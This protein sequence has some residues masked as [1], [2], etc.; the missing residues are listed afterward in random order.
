VPS[1]DLAACAPLQFEPP[2]LDTFRCLALAFDA[3]RAGGDA[4]AILN[5][6]NEVAV[7]AFL[8]GT[9]PFLGIAEVVER[10]LTELPT[11][12]VV[13]VPTLCERD[14]LAR[15]AARRVLRSAC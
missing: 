13:D 15:A 2:D 4:P 12:R 9:L 11:Q 8:A 3:L 6:A 14:V 10:V 7:E 5:A 1:L